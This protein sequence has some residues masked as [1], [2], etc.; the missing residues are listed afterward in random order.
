MF[1]LAHAALGLPAP[2]ILTLWHFLVEKLS[3]IG[4]LGSDSSE[5]RGACTGT[6]AGS[7]L[8]RRFKTLGG[9]LGVR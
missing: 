8:S 3:R 6:V 5:D 9:Y 4:D 7:L 1:L 2:G